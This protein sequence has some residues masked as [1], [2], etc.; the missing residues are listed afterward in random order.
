MATR[1]FDATVQL[2]GSYMGDRWWTGEQIHSSWN[3]ENMNTADRSQ[4]GTDANGWVQYRSSFSSYAIRYNALDQTLDNYYFETDLQPA[5]SG[6]YEVGVTFRFKDRFSFYYLTFNGGYQ[7]WGGNNIRLMKVSGTTHTKVAE[8]TTPV[9]NPATVYKFRVELNGANIRILKDG[10]EIFNYTDAFPI[11]KGA[12]GPI[13]KGQEF[14]KWKGFQA[15]STSSFVLQKAFLNNTLTNEY[16][17]EASSKLLVPDEIGI[18]MQAEIDLYFSDK[19]YNSRTFDKFTASS[20][21]SSVKLIFDRTMDKNM[22]TDATSKL[23]AYQ[24]LPVSP[25]LA[26]TN[27]QGQAQNSTD[28]LLTWAHSDWSEDGFFIQD[29]NSVT[30][31]TVGEDVYTFTEIGLAEGTTYTRQVV[32]FNSAGTSA[33]TNAVAITTK[34]TPP[35][36]PSEFKGEAVDDE[37]IKWTWLDNSFNE[38]EFELIGWND[39]GQEAVFATLPAGTTEYIEKGLTY[40]TDYT[41]SIRAKNTAGTS[42]AATELTVKTKDWLPDPPTEAPVNFYGVTTA[43]DRIVWSWEDW[44]DNVDGFELVDENDKVLYRLTKQFSYTETDLYSKMQ[45]AR[46]I[47]AYNTGGVGPA[48]VYA[49]VTTMGY[50]YDYTG[51]P[52]EPFNLTDLDIGTD[53]LEI[54]WDYE[55]EVTAP[56]IGFK[57]YNELDMLV[58]TLSLE[59]NSRK[60][61]G[62][63]PDTTYNL[64]VVAYNEI[65]DSLPSNE[66]TI[67][68]LPEDLDP[69]DVPEEIVALDDPLYGL[70]YDREAIDTPKIQAFQSGIG[71]G[72]DLL[73]KNLFEEIP[74]FEEFVYELSIK[75]YY[76]D[77]GMYYPEVPFQFQVTA[78]GVDMVT[79][80][81]FTKKSDWFKGMVKGEEGG[82]GLT[83]ESSL[84]MSI[85]PTITSKKFSI[86]VQDM[87]G[88]PMPSYV[89]D[90]PEQ[91]V[92]WLLDPYEFEEIVGTVNGVY[93]KNVFSEWTKFS[94]QGTNQPANAHELNAWSYNASTDEIVCTENTGTYVGAVSPDAYNNFTLNSTFR[95]NVADNDAMGI[96]IAFAKDAAGREYTLSA[97]RNHTLTNKWG[98]YYN[99]LQSN[100]VLLAEDV[101]FPIA[102]GNWNTFYPNGT[103]IEVSRHDDEIVARTSKAGDTVLGYAISINLN[104]R[105][106]LAVFKGPKPIGVSSW[107][108]QG[109]SLKIQTFQGERTERYTAYNMRAWTTYK[110]YRDV[111]KEWES[112]KV[113]SPVMRVNA[114][115][116]IKFTGRIQSPLYQIPWQKL[117]AK[118]PFNESMYKLLITTN[119]PNIEL[120]IESSDIDYFM[121]NSTFVNIPLSAKIV[122]YTQTAWNPHV[123]HGYYYLN[124]RE[125][126]LF[127]DDKVLPQKDN[128]IA[129]YVYTFPYIIKAYGERNYTEGDVTFT[130]DSSLQFLIGKLGAGVD[131]D[132]VNNRL[133]LTS[134]ATEG[135]FESRLFD[136]EMPINIWNPIT[137]TTTNTDGEPVGIEVGAADEYGVVTTWHP[138]ENGA[139]ITL[140]EVTERIRYRLTMKESKKA[141]P[142]FLDFNM[143]NNILGQGFGQNIQIVDELLSID[144]PAFI[145]TASYITKP[146]DYGMM[147][148]DMGLFTSDID[149]PGDTR[150]ELYSV[151]SPDQTH[152]FK[153]PTAESP[154]IPLELV[155]SVGTQKTYRI[156]SMKNQWVVIV[157]KLFRG[158]NTTDQIYE[159]PTINHMTVQAQLF[160]WVR[161]VPEVTSVQVGASIQGGFGA[162]DYVIPMNG[163]LLAD[164]QTQ[165]ITTIKAADIVANWLA[166]QGVANLGELVLKDFFVEIDPIYPVEL[167]TDPSGMEVVTGKTTASVGDLIWKQEKLYFDQDRQDIVLQPIPQ[168]GSPI[169]ITNAQ[170]R[171]LRP[172]HFRDFVGEATLTNLQETETDESRYLFLD[173]VQIDPATLH[174]YIDLEKNGNYEE[175]FNCRLEENRIIL[176]VLYPPRLSVKLSYRIKDSFCVHYNY[177]TKN[178][179]AKVDVHT[180]FDPDVKATRELTVKYEVNKE[181]P[182]HLLSEVNLNPLRNKINS[183]FLYLTDEIYAPYRLEVYANPTILY[184]N[185]EDMVTINAYVL[186]EFNNP[187][188]GE[189]VNFFS[190]GGQVDVHTSITDESGLVTATYKS[191]KDSTNSEEEIEV[192][193]IGRTVS[194]HLTKVLKIDLV[195]ESFV[196][197][198]ALVPEKRM[199]NAGDVVQLKVIAM[200]PNNERLVNK[201]V[202]ITANVGLLVP[203]SGTTNPDGELYINYSLPQTLEEP[204]IILEANSTGGNGMIV[205]EQ[206]ILGISGV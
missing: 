96:V 162:E 182:Y 47:R 203:T 115:E 26:P 39:A 189:R 133:T 6:N 113:T 193:V 137:V 42:L 97:I 166:S 163:E 156:R 118:Y 108:Q 8:Y 43:A 7:D 91:K 27:L 195:E 65:G 140:P 30:V 173:Y 57:V 24:L 32:A 89:P 129:T 50:G 66:I 79:D 75:G 80:Q 139:V 151:S 161:T 198:L 76:Q 33:P 120:K 134:S 167:H 29:E 84:S 38:N 14:A 40:L 160:N 125:H 164:G 104:D 45:Y 9:F 82:L 123:H 90:I 200:G 13:V 101:T 178:D 5:G 188:V 122:N 131:V 81:A 70:T 25:P 199:V 194:S 180:S 58:D 94:H 105:P 172:V 56:A 201:E 88:N 44:N 60:I 3:V 22:T 165:P 68:T 10:L 46:K 64:Y 149:V 119:N 63:L 145:Q 202:Q 171:Q 31:G 159:S 192:S 153:N 135:I 197:K 128:S 12:F 196:D 69:P 146:L 102:G 67:T 109:A 51:H 184:R 35:A 205:R 121:E 21:N 61:E 100:E 92:N 186:D 55:N 62:L 141:E 112:P 150:I 176:P 114:F 187:V 185:K 168:T 15:K 127:A 157:A 107:S 99:F 142:F 111:Y 206:N 147:I 179:Y 204:F 78:T 34:Q 143:N 83:F 155:S 73:V 52:V 170:G 36:P 117:A 49:Y 124:Q 148:A 169:I 74:N 87:D 144:N 86:E 93:M 54:G 190:E 116:E 110:E 130:D 77:E 136:F 23:Y 37:S 181:H 98:I 152:D 138:Q 175:I 174:I 154:W 16:H 85:P 48:T 11:L 191:L 19:V 72:M 18:A 28:I 183:G 158:F 126:Y 2:E 103:V 106:E 177:D 53:Y 4:W 132:A 20:S 71:D 1:Q 17:D 41:R 95:S 59:V